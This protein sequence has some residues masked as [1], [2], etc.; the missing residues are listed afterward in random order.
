M[1]QEHIRQDDRGT[2]FFADHDLLKRIDKNPVGKLART[3]FE[4]LGATCEFISQVWQDSWSSC[5]VCSGAV[6]GADIYH[7]PKSRVAH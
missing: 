1:N 2:I 4:F 6:V 5:P 3:E 7:I